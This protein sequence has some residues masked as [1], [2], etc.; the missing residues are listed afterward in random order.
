MEST[1]QDRCLPRGA[2]QEFF[3]YEHYITAATTSRL[4][5]GSDELLLLGASGMNRYLFADLSI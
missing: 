1:K 4:L 2:Y 5:L 3:F